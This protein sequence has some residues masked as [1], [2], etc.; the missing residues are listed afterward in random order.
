MNALQFSLILLLFVST[1]KLFSQTPNSNW[2]RLSDMPTAR[3]SSHSI[4]YGDRIYVFG[5]DNSGAV[6][7][8][9][10]RT[11]T[12]E[13]K[14]SFPGKEFNWSGIGLSGDTVFAVI[15]IGP[16]DNTKYHVIA[17]YNI[18]SDEWKRIDSTSTA[19]NDPAVAIS[20]RSIYL[21]SGYMFEGATFG[22]GKFW[23][24]DS[25]K[26]YNLDTKQWRM[27]AKIPTKRHAAV[28]IPIDSKIYVFS[29]VGDCFCAPG[30]NALQVYDPQ[31]DTWSLKSTVTWPMDYFRGSRIGD[32]IYFIAANKVR[33]YNIITDSWNSDSPI[34]YEGSMFSH[35]VYNNTIYIFGGW[36]SSF[37]AINKVF[38]YIPD[39]M[40]T[41][42]DG[43]V[44]RTVKIGDQT[45]L[46][47]NLKSVHY[48]DGKVITGIHN[49]MN[50][51]ISEIY[52]RFYTWN[53][54]MNNS[55]IASTQG[56]CPTG[57]HVPGD[58]EWKVLEDYLGGATIAAA[59]LKE[60]GTLHWNAPNVGSTNESGFTALPGGFWAE[61]G[62][63]F[64]LGAA[65]NIWT[66]TQVGTGSA[67]MRI[68][69]NGK[70]NVWINTEP[71]S[72]AFSVRCL[73]DDPTEIKTINQVK[74]TKID[75]YPNPF[76]FSVSIQFFLQKSGF[77]D[78]KIFNIQGELIETLIAHNLT[79]G[80]HQATWEPEN[81][82]AG[83]YYC[84]FT[85]ENF[86]E[87]KKIL[88]LE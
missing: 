5:G 16:R 26:V 12:W 9:S 86:T 33:V 30:S 18:K 52:G 66:S 73:K 20:G 4:N 11:N 49:N 63:T 6:E 10:P 38:A 17:S 13:I 25:V 7:V 45:W 53:A 21:I 28:A 22:S 2:T 74:K 65:S 87:T 46:Q 43:N 84:T 8:Y 51:S 42:F 37:I 56:V 64:S 60:S 61:E 27:K 82:K 58:N 29:G 81:L 70:N 83:I 40:V 67:K 71:K 41:D 19:V 48:S 68:L 15:G 36:N 50:D 78:L 34:S 57:W 80:E 62:V 54:A 59:K 3:S 1:G 39:V 55:T 47:E 32:K 79:Q 72:N 88:L 23:N 69:E 14:K 85:I 77:V 44:Y 75:V 24:T 76:N 31:T 35:A